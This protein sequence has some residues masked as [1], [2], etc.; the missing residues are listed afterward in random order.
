[1]LSLLRKAA[2]AALALV[3]CAAAPL[4]NPGDFPAPAP[5]RTAAELAYEQVEVLEYM[6][7]GTPAEDTIIIWGPCWQENAFFWPPEGPIVLCLELNSDGVFVA[8]HE[9]AHAL[10]IRMGMDPA[11]PDFVERRLA[12]ERA[13]DDLATLFLIE[14]GKQDEVLQ[15]VRWFMRHWEGPRKTGAHP[16]S[17]DRA[18]RMLCLLDGSEE[19]DHVWTPCAVLYRNTWY[20]WSSQ[21]QLSLDPTTPE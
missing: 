15:G 1:V 7:Q 18:R 9:G 12:H 13:A 10:I 14:M 8:A 19:P 17:Q 6:L 3:G 16:L 20:Y 5:P 11:G 2:I 21:F 4:Y